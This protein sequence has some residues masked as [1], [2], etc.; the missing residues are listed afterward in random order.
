MSWYS[1]QESHLQPPRSK[2]LA[3]GHGRAD[4]CA[5]GAKG[6]KEDCE[7][8]TFACVVRTTPEHL[9]D[10]SIRFLPSKFEMGPTEALACGHLHSRGAI[11]PGSLRNCRRVQTPVA[12]EPDRRNGGSPRCC[13]VLCGLRDRC[14]AASLAT[15]NKR[16]AKAELNRRDQA[17][18]VLADTGIRVARIIGPRVCDPQQP[19]HSVWFVNRPRRF[20]RWTCCGSQSR[21][22]KMNQDQGSAPCIPVWKVL[23]DG[24]WRVSLNTYARRNGIPCWNRTSLC[25]FANRRLS[26]SANG[27]EIESAGGSVRL[28]LGCYPSCVL[29]PDYFRI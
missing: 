21:A 12:A 10:F 15:R 19:R 11:A 14:I 16:D 27:M 28:R 20:D 2:V 8:Q 6:T 13:P 7:E 5:T 22:P 3:H 4:N 18:E 26:C 25:G 17:C 24:Q 29:Q 9:K 1:W 23:A